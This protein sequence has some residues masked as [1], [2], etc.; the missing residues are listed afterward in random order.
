MLLVAGIDALGAVAGKEILVELQARDALEDRHADFLGAA[1]IDGRLEDDDV[2]LLQH[3]ADRLARP[4]DRRQVGSLV[5]VDRRRHRDDED[6]Q[7]ARS[8]IR[9]V[10]V[11]CFADAQL[12]PVT[13]SVLS[14]PRLSSGDRARLDVETDGSEVLAELDGERQADIAETDDADLQAAAVQPRGA[15][16][17]AKR[18]SLRTCESAKE[19]HIR[20]CRY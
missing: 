2:A 20:T 10:K 6:L 18:Y 9:V 3:L 1:G 17:A 16:V 11:S 8:S 5:L 12:A 4:L 14:W 15:F 13:S 7:S 19:C